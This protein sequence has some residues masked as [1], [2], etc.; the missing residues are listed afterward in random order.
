MNTTLSR[1]PDSVRSGPGSRPC[2]IRILG[3]LCS[4]EV[5]E[6][7]DA[8]AAG[9]TLQV[10]EEGRGREEEGRCREEEGR[11]RE[12]EEGR[13]KEGGREEEGRGREEE[14]RCREESRGREEAFKGRLEKSMRQGAQ[15]Y[16]TASREAGNA[17]PGV[18]R[19]GPITIQGEEGSR[20][21]GMVLE[22]HIHQEEPTL[23][24]LSCSSG[25]LTALLGLMG[26]A[27]LW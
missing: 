1:Q 24:A 7:L 25:M 4:H 9:I 17:R 3:M 20:G 27:V 6:G 21:F 13:C 18:G 26:H 15:V 19:R 12:E 2:C 23:G 5:C 10:K 11:C 8:R 22:S 14:G 16:H